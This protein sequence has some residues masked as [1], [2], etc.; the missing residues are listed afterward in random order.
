MER[1]KKYDPT[2][3]DPYDAFVYTETDIDPLLDELERLRFYFL[4]IGNEV[5]P[6]K[7]PF[8]SLE[9]FKEWYMRTETGGD[10]WAWCAKIM[11][12]FAQFCY[13][14]VVFPKVGQEYEGNPFGTN[15]LVRGKLGSFR[16][17]DGMR[18][19]YCDTI[20]PVSRPTRE[21]V[22]AKHGLTDEEL[23]VLGVEI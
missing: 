18:N 1:P 17:S 9:E 15:K 5:T 16:L 8:P 21:E 23:A 19:W 4:G 22:V 12:Y 2:T 3:L 13:E 20:R 6:N 10:E 11:D 7:K 14:K